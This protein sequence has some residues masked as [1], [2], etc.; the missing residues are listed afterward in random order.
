MEELLE[1][2]AATWYKEPG[3][4]SSQI[5]SLEQELKV[6]LP[7]DYRHFLLWSDGGEGDIGKC[8]LSLWS[9]GEIPQLNSD[10]LI[11][12]YVPGLV[13][14]GTD[15]GSICYALDFRQDRVSPSFVSV[16]LGDL[17]YESVVII[18]PTFSEG[19]RGWR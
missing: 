10:Y 13:G 6:T 19:L 3:A 11:S 12:H 9:I 7:E 15:G 5:E 8:Y 18:A 4:N 14:I 17:D 2:I 16:P 1:E